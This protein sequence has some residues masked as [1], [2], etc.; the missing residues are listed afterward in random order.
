MIRE[1]NIID[2]EE[3]LAIHKANGLPE[4]CFP[5]LYIKIG[6][7]YEKNA[8]FTDRYVMEHEDQLRMA[9]FLKATAEIY[10]VVDH[11]IGTPEERLTWLTEMKDFMADR[12][13]RRG[14]E[15]VSCW[16]PPD[17]EKSFAPRLIELGFQKSWQSYTFNL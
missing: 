17:L 12:A 9:C 16:I 6:E 1:F 8:L 2:L 7:E 15:Q 13:R 11:T 3:V 10:L 14:Y 4:N 5:D